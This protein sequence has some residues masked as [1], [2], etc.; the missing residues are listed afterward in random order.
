MEKKSNNA[1]WQQQTKLILLAAVV[2][3]TGYCHGRSRR[4]LEEV[5]N[6]IK[7]VDEGNVTKVVHV[8][9]EYD[10]MINFEQLFLETALSFQP[11]TDKVTSHKYQVMYGQ[12]LLP[13]YKKH[14]NMKFLEIGL[15]CDMGYGPGA[16]VK[17]WQTLFPT[18]DLWEAEY[19]GACVAK[20]RSEGKLEGIKTLV[21]DQANVTVLQQ[22]ITESGGD[23]DVIIDDGGHHNCHIW[24]SFLKL[25]PV[26]KPGGLYFIEDMQVARKERYQGASSPVCDKSLIVP[27]KLK[28]MIDG[29]IYESPD[30]EGDVKFIFCQSEACVIGKRDNFD[31]YP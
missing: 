25:W 30:T 2:Y 4:M 28:E 31:R 19:N 27:E 21:G 20:S 10:E 6:D 17:V 15:G 12:H 26:L 5:K 18:A 11:I 23:F 16:S 14:P 13:Y 24:T 1:I 3:I 22:W 8:V 7:R 29:L 9:P